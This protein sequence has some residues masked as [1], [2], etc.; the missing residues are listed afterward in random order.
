MYLN[1]INFINVLDLLQV[2]A[3]RPTD[4]VPEAIDKLFS[5]FE[6][7]EIK[8]DTVIWRQGDLPDKCLILAD[9][10][11]LNSLEEE[12]GTTEVIEVGHLVGEFS[13]MVNQRRLGTLSAI[14]NSVIF[15]LSKMKYDM[16]ISTEPYL[17]FVLARICMVR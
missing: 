15:V 1:I 3:L 7:Q 14:D 17:A 6:R 9:G 2:H 11:L 5:F 10:R 8:S 16:I 13:L 12:A 4:V